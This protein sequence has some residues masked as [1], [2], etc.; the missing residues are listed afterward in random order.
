MLFHGSARVGVL[1]AAAVAAPLYRFFD[2]DAGCRFASREE[3]ECAFKIDSATSLFLSGVAQDHEVERWWKL[4]T[5]GRVKAIANL[6]RL[7]VAMVTTPNFSVTVDR[8]RWDDLH[9]MRRIAEVFHELVSEGQAAALHINGRT[10]RDFAR[11]AEYVSIHPEVTHIAYEFTTGAKSPDRMRQHAQWL[12][13]FA[14]AS[15]RRLGLIVRGGLP[16]VLP[17]SRHFDISFIDSSPFEKAHHREIA[18]I[19]ADGRRRWVKRMTPEGMPID[20]L[21]HDNI[22]SSERWFADLMPKL[23]LAA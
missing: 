14:E 10:R 9:S 16:V 11:W 8:P 23:A 17:L 13:E 4:E 15:G 6:R 22:V 12:I 7:G 20:T 3:V 5:Q 19:D 21:L 18:M 1:S 2:K